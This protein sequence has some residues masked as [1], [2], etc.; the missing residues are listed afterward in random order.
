MKTQD[1]FTEGCEKAVD[2]IKNMK[3]FYL[4]KT[5]QTTE[6]NYTATK[7]NANKANLIIIRSAKRQFLKGERYAD[8]RKEKVGYKAK[9]IQM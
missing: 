7:K 2:K 9:N 3:I 8:I 4:V 5:D 1:L 6:D